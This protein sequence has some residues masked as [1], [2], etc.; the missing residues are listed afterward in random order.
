MR[1][2]GPNGMGAV[3]TAPAARRSAGRTFSLG[4]PDA[5]H[6]APQNA[7]PRTVGGIDALMA[8]QGVEDAMQRRRRAVNRGRGALDALDA[9]KLGLLSARLDGAAVARLTTA[10]ADLAEPSGDPALDAIL[11]EIGLRVGVELAKIGMPNSD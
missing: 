3:A 9:L 2:Y 6:S 7:A 8:L 4:E 10:L 11:A 5:S 1:V